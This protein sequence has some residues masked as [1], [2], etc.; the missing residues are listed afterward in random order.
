[1]LSQL[2][3]SPGARPWL[4]KAQ[5]QVGP[6]RLELTTSSLSEMRSN[7]LSYGPKIDDIVMSVGERSLQG[8]SS[9]KRTFRPFKTEPD[10]S[11][12]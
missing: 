4:G 9:L 11:V 12:L 10:D 7:Q 5:N 1:M 2:S 3:Y 6:V 8:S